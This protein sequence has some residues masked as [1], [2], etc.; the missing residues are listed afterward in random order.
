[1]AWSQALDHHCLNKSDTGSTKQLIKTM[2]TRTSANMLQLKG[3]G[4]RFVR[5]IP[6][7]SSAILL[8]RSTNKTSYAGVQYD[9]GYY[10]AKFVRAGVTIQAGSFRAELERDVETDTECAIMLKES[11]LLHD[12]ARNTIEPEA[13]I[14]QFSYVTPVGLSLQPQGSRS[15]PRLPFDPK[16]RQEDWNSPANLFI[17]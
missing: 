3:L 11:I 2:T 17:P 4:G 1:M 10:M 13:S 9:H 6:S 14:P 7:S 5:V 16:T 15:P 8:P 12:L